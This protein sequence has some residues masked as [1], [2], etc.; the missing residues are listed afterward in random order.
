MTSDSLYAH[1]IR[2]SILKPF[3]LQTLAEAVQRTFTDGKD[4]PFL[5][6]REL[7]YDTHSPH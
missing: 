3:T 5:I 4:A 6:K 1:G 7:N 2:E